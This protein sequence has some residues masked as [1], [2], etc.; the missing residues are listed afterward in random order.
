ME[1]LKSALKS[2][3][4]WFN[5]VTGLVSIAGVLPIDPATSALIVAV[6][7][8]ALRFITTEPLSAK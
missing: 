6:G 5:L 4:I 1:Q 8:V 2:K 3:T 7:N